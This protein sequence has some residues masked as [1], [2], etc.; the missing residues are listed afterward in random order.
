M[1][2]IIN[3]LLLLSLLYYVKVTFY[4]NKKIKMVNHGDTK[5]KYPRFRC[6]SPTF[7]DSHGKAIKTTAKTV[8]NH[9]LLCIKSCIKMPKKRKR[10]LFSSFIF[11][12]Y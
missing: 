8:G 10:G 4:K 5:I 9:I 2:I 7:I 11:L 3:N 1:L 12:I 6:F